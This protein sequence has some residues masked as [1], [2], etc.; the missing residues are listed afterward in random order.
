VSDAWVGSVGR[1]RTSA[2]RVAGI[3]EAIDADE[4]RAPSALPGWSRAHVA[5]HIA[6]NAEGFARALSTQTLPE[7]LPVYDSDE[8]RGAGVDQL[9]SATKAEVLDRLRAADDHLARLL[10]GLGPDERAG[11]L[12][13]TPGGISFPV[14]D[15]PVTRRRELEVHAIDLGVS[16]RR[17]SWPADFVVE[18]LDCPTWDRHD[19]GPFVVRADDLARSWQVGDEGGPVIA[20][21]GAELGWWL[22]G[23]SGAEL[24][25][26]LPALS[27]WVRRPGP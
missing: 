24:A 18:L 21:R 25:G 10:E 7:P 9:S 14:A 13:R 2:E 23:R 27:P 4:W 20:G 11:A 5:A 15:L 22:T 17:A 6:L 19:D 16:V 3:I 1:L 8:A 12:A 26:A